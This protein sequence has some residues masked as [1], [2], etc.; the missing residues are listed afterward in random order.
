MF[1]PEF[2]KSSLCA[3]LGSVTAVMVFSRVMRA[4]LT[5]PAAME[6]VTKHK[7][8]ARYA[9]AL[10]VANELVTS[11]PQ[12]LRA[13]LLFIEALNDVGQ[14]DRA[15]VE[16]DRLELERP[17]NRDVADLRAKLF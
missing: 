14:L 13:R 15:R 17:G 2:I 10:A 8:A 5:A 3:I 12:N 7:G 4:S 1:D 6:L 11:H 16:I 9:D